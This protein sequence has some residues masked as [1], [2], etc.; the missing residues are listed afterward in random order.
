VYAREVAG[1][2]LTFLVSGKLWRNSLI[3]QDEE[4]G[5][6]WSHIT[7]EALEGELAGMTLEV[8][9]SVQ[10]DWQ[11]WRDRHPQTRLLVKD[12]D[13]TGSRYADYLDDPERTGL[14]R[15]QWLTGRLPGKTL[16]YGIHDGP[17]AAAV[18]DDFLVD[19]RAREIE[20]GDRTVHVRRGEDG[21]VR[22][23]HATGDG[24]TEPIDVL[25]VFWFAWSGFYPHT[26]VYD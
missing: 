11:R 1:R 7:G 10:A 17:R 13:I 23:W 5:T 9:E 15:A 26:E 4:T 20:L 14:F 25:E 8:V 24:Q 12:T 6:L 18:T 19:G 22:A 21:G 2:E 3:M 16:V